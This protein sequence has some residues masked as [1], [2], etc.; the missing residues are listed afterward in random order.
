MAFTIE[1]LE[2][3]KALGKLGVDDYQSDVVEWIYRWDGGNLWD[4]FGEHQL[5]YV[6]RER[7]LWLLFLGHK[8]SKNASRIDRSDGNPTEDIFLFNYKGKIVDVLLKV[9]DECDEYMSSQF[10]RPFNTIYEF[11]KIN[12]SSFDDI[13]ELGLK[14][15]ICEALAT[16]NRDNM[17]KYRGLT[18]AKIET[19]IPT[20]C[21]M[22]E[23]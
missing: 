5:I 8:L 4:E 19:L 17:D 23:N 13:D 15:L 11:V 3:R 18:F 21:K 12:P 6:D 2:D 1:Y 20:K 14:K 22:T 16:P 9:S 7:D 10:V